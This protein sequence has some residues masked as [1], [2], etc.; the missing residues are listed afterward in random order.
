VGS[1]RGDRA[2]GAGGRGDQEGGPDTSARQR[3]GAISTKGKG[4]TD[5]VARSSS[6]GGGRPGCGTA[7]ARSPRCRD[8]GCAPGARPRP[9]AAARSR[10]P[11]A[12]RGGRLRPARPAPVLLGGAVAGLLV[13]SLQVAD[14]APA[15]VTVDAARCPL[16]EDTAKT[17]KRPAPSACRR[18][19]TA[20]PSRASGT[21]PG[22]HRAW[23]GGPPWPARPRRTPGL[24]PPPS[25]FREPRGG[26]QRLLTVATSA[27]RAGVSTAEKVASPSCDG[28][29]PRW[30]AGPAR[31]AR[32]SA[33]APGAG[34]PPGCG[35]GPAPRDPLGQA[36]RLHRPGRGRQQGPQ[37]RVPVRR[38]PG[39]GL[40]HPRHRGAAARATTCA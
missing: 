21:G 26:S 9:E 2:R 17:W 12:T 16:G 15:A 23:R 29:D 40:R 4:S 37:A 30:C 1:A 35:P 13:S 33:H 5:P 24:R 31:A 18:L 28:A 39:P 6:C 25:R 7:R 14:H 22:R 20:A 8:R 10:R 3:P 11:G 38:G 27:C 36:R 32:P 19:P 34:R